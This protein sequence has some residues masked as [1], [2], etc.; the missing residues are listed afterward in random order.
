MRIPLTGFVPPLSKR[1]CCD[2]SPE[3]TENLSANPTKTRTV[4][5]ATVS[6]LNSLTTIFQ[7]RISVP[8]PLASAAIYGVADYDPRKTSRPAETD[9]SS[10]TYFH[11]R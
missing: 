4:S 9:A 8:W 11:L 6:P 10:A 5:G 7:F 2:G 1:G 3:Q